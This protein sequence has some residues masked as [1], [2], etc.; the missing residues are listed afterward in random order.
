MTVAQTVVA[1]LSV[2]EAGSNQGACPLTPGQTVTITE[3]ETEI[4][5]VLIDEGVF[6]SVVTADEW[7]LQVMWRARDSAEYQARLE[8]WRI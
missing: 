2:R 6:A 7:L 3:V 5:H 1:F 4:R 8:R